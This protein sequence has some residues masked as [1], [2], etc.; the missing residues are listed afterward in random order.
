MPMQWPA[1]STLGVVIVAVATALCP[2]CRSKQTTIETRDFSQNL[3]SIAAHQRVSLDDT[4]TFFRF[5]GT[6][7][8]TVM[9]PERVIIRTARAEQARH[10]H[11]TAAAVTFSNHTR[12]S[13]FNK[14]PSLPGWANETLYTLTLG[15]IL[16]FIVTY[17]ARKS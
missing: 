16:L 3:R 1:V 12:E 7:T 9:V 17:I 5:D 2:S 6:D 8:G 11:D 10:Q 4:L 14:T 13:S 15:V